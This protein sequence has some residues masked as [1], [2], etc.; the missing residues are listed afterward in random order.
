MGEKQNEPF[1]LTFNNF[2]KVDFESSRFTSDGGVI[3]VRELDEQLGSLPLPAGS[4]PQ[5]AG[6][7]LGKQ[8]GGY[9]GV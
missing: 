6:E 4:S 1:Q 3:L 7:N 8:A 9:R 2:S 5:P